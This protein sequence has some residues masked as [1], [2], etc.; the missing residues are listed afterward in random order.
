LSYEWCRKAKKDIIKRV[1]RLILQVPSRRKQTRQ[2]KKLGQSRR[3]A[4]N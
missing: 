4:Q 1:I 3:T 2:G